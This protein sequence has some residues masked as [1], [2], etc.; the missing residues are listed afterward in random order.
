[1]DNNA[2]KLSLDKLSKNEIPTQ[3]LYERF[4][5]KI[6]FNI[7]GDY[8]NFISQNDGAEGDIGKEKYL[9]LWDIENILACNPYYED[10]EVCNNLLFFGTDGSNYGYAFNKKTN[11]IIGIDFLDIGSVP[12]D[13]IAN[14][15]K[16][17]LTNLNN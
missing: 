17:F 5:E 10:V 14:S 9:S 7:D 3:S 2:Y 11:K 1:M 6:D 12:P 15:F 16:E 4:L 8:L 13:E